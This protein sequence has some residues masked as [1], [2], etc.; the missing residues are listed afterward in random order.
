MNEQMRCKTRF[1]FLLSSKKQI[2]KNGFQIK[3]YASNIKE[4]GCIEG[5]EKNGRPRN[6]SSDFVLKKFHW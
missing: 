1:P 3:S 6:N 4:T 5:V 2:Y